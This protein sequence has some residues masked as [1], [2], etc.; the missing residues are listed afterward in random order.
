MASCL[1][2]QITSGSFAQSLHASDWEPNSFPLSVTLDLTSACNLKC[3]HCFLGPHETAPP[4][5]STE[6]VE[7]VLDVLKQFGVLFLV[8]TG[9]EP[10]SRPDFKRLYL[11][12]KHNGFFMTLFSNGTLLNEELMDF[13]ADAP[14]RRLELTIYGHTEQVYERVTGIPGS[15]KRFRAAV[16]G[17][18]SRDLLVRL[19]SMI[20]RSNAHELDDIRA[21]ATGLGCDFRYDALI[22]PCLDQATLPLS[23]R[24]TPSEIAQFRYRDRE[25][26]AAPTPPGPTRNRIPARQFLF[27]CG[28]GIMTA[29]I[30]SQHQVHPCISWRNDPFDLMAHPSLHAWTQHITRLRHKPSP[31]GACDNCLDRA[32]CQCCVALSQLESG[33]PAKPVPFFCDLVKEEQ[34][35]EVFPLS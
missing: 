34:K 12:A 2:H 14:P 19:K 30:D 1:A 26:I 23:E 35:L 16:D 10:F 21:W 15:F 3:R 11:K 17:L 32:Q 7:Q 31:G 29:H 22:H 33:H 28:A 4:Q 9:G 8:F 5:K 18:L 24:L 25:R 13:L 6:E 20:M 27:E